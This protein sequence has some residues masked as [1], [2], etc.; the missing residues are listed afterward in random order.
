METKTETRGEGWE[1]GA[2][3]NAGCLFRV[4]RK[5]DT[6]VALVA[7]ADQK[8]G[9]A[10]QARQG[11][12]QGKAA[13]APCRCI[14]TSLFASAYGTIKSPPPPASLLPF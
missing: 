2:F 12:G 3:R 10:D 5:L 13:S 7:Q 1:E 11:R 9:R 8:E 6:G 4:M 14:N